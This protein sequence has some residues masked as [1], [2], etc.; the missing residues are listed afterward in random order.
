MPREIHELRAVVLAEAKKATAALNAL[1]RRAES[2]AGS[3][4][5]SAQT[6]TTASN[7]IKGSVRNMERGVSA[8]S[9]KARKSLAGLTNDF[10]LL[11]RKSHLSTTKM[12]SSMGALTSAIKIQTAQMR[13]MMAKLATSW[14][15][16]A[17]AARSTATSTA[18]ASRASAAAV[19]ASVTKQVFHL[20]TLMGQIRT[21]A[22]SWMSVGSALGGMLTKITLAVGLFGGYAVKVFA[23]F[24]DTMIVVGAVTQASAKEFDALNDAARTAGETTRFTARESAEAMKTLGLAGLSVAEILGGGLK[25]ALQLASAA[26]LDI[27]SAA[28]ISAKSMRAFG[29][30]A[31]D[32]TRINNTLVGTF[33]QANTDLT[34]LAEGLKYAG[35]LARAAGVSFE[36]TTA[37][38]GKLADAGMAASLGGTGLRQVLSR[39]TGGVPAVTKKLRE[40]GVETLRAD[41]AMRN[42]YDILRDIEAAAMSPGEVMAMFGARGGTQM[43]EM[44]KVGSVALKEFEDRTKA[45]GDVAEELE[46]KRLRGLTGQFDLL[47]SAIESVFLDAG[48]NL[49]PALQRVNEQFRLML[50]DNKEVLVQAIATSFGMLVDAARNVI[51]SIQ[52]HGPA[53]KEV[54]KSILFVV[55]AVG[56]FLRDH[57]RFLQALLALQI[58]RM[59]GVLGFFKTLALAIWET[60]YAMTGLKAAV[61]GAGGMSV[62]L[63]NFGKMLMGL[64]I[65]A[66]LVNPLTGA[67]A[68]GVILGTVFAQLMP[69]MI[70]FRREAAKG[71]E[72]TKDMME[73]QQ[74]R[75]EAELERINAITDATERQA[76]LQKQLDLAERDKAGLDVQVKSAQEYVESTP[77]GSKKREVAE[78]ELAETKARVAAADQRIDQLRAAMLG[79]AVEQKFAKLARDAVTG[80]VVTDE[81]GQAVSDKPMAEMGGQKPGV[82]REPDL[83]ERLSSEAATKRKESQA[84]RR[85]RSAIEERDR[86]AR[87]GKLGDHAGIMEM[88]Q[89]EDVGREAVTA[90]ADSMRGSTP[91]IRKAFIDSMTAALTEGATTDQLGDI[92]ATALEKSEAAEKYGE[93]VADMK[94]R[95]D[96]KVRKT[97]FLPESVIAKLEA[98]FQRMADIYADSPELAERTMRAIVDEL[99][100][101][102]KAAQSRH[103]TGQSVLKSGIT[104]FKD[105]GGSLP[106]AGGKGPMVG[107]LKSILIGGFMDAMR[108]FKSGKM[109]EEDYSSRGEAIQEAA[110]GLAEFNDHLAAVGVSLPK[111]ELKSFQTQ[112]LELARAVAD[113]S[114]SAEQAAN[115]HDRLSGALEEASQAAERRRLASGQFTGG[116]FRKAM[117]DKMIQYQRSAFDNMVNMAFQQRLSFLGNSIGGAAGMFNSLQRGMGAFGNALSGRTKQLNQVATMGAQMAAQLFASPAGQRARIESELFQQTQNMKMVF[118][119]NIHSP[120]A[121]KFQRRIQELQGQLAQLSTPQASPFSG[122]SGEVPGAMS[123]ASSVNHTN[124]GSLQ[125][126]MNFPNMTSMSNMSDRDVSSLYERLSREGGR[127]GIRFG[128]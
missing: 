73:K 60:V 37:I 98:R 116:E 8:A 34:Q 29:L 124:V 94:D 20:R 10:T 110:T 50:S 1:A 74:K 23:E 64:R 122:V 91:A 92:V 114:M 128:G 33:T 35:P 28:S 86:Q 76:E 79:T 81:D 101:A 87:F 51:A 102:E 19:G 53:F 58:A 83:L 78:T 99:G 5:K 31:T 56:A 46:Q 120:G 17:A 30:E 119:E 21:L 93:A 71:A 127:R 75:F 16:T 25:G 12:G 89:D 80:G 88:V 113:G 72:L 45:L 57:P 55:S 4:K 6:I 18:A 49:E 27:A 9:T 109:S 44:L 106:D 104:T 26:G 38:L 105:V 54:G 52:E 126:A 123:G 111:D 48:D 117:Q 11:Q 115:A 61:T 108:Q 118:G 15:G 36:T 103:E 7:Q 63:G 66:F 121:Q 13:A 41:E 43:L 32:L 95:F 97:E 42:F 112:S 40:M 70:A 3:W 100:A 2:L 84:A 24:Q 62:I 82:P 39:L 90:I 69:S 14:A 59:L 68:A 22:G 85:T 107:G 77:W 96:Q 125:M 65:T 47:R 67:I